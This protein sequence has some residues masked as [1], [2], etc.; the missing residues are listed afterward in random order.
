VFH[1]NLQ[2]AVQLNVLR[3]FDNFSL[4]VYNKHKNMKYMLVQLDI[5]IYNLLLI[6]LKQHLLMIEVF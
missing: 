2:F 4:L 5:Y 3:K 6:Y 1:F